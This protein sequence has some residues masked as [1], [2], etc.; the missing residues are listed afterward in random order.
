MS[1]RSN[2]YKRYLDLRE[3]FAQEFVAQY[4]Y[5]LTLVTPAQLWRALHRRFTFF[6]ERL[7]KGNVSNVY[8]KP[9][10]EK[11]KDLYNHLLQD[12]KYTRKKII[13][14]EYHHIC[15]Y[16]EYFNYTP[17]VDPNDVLFEPSLFAESH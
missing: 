9:F 6:F 17:K 12:P 15:L 11:V 14:K 13:L 5:Y 8:I 4:N 10:L 2:S 16:A 1:S 3:L 7:E